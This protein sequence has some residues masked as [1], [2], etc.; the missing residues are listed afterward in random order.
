M[1]L[2]M[3][4]DVE[5]FAFLFIITYSSNLDHTGYIRQLSFDHWKSI[6]TKK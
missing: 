2:A 6:E 4:N 1:V 5:I 3:L